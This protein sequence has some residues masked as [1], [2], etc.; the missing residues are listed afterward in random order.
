LVAIPRSTGYETFCRHGRETKWVSNLL[1]ALGG[2]DGQEDTLL[3]FLSFLSRSESYRDTWAEG[4]CLNGYP[5]PTIDEVTDKGNPIIG[6]YK[7][8]ANATAKEL[9]SN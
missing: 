9:S 8:G 2:D 4:V 3:N 6:E 7:S 1:Y 5:M